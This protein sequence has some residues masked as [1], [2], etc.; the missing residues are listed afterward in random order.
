MNYCVLIELSK[1]KISFLY[2]RSDG[3]SRFV[4]FEGDG[5][6][7]PLAIFCQGNDIQIGQFAIDEARKGNP[8]AYVNVFDIITNRGTYKYRGEDCPYSTILF[9]AI[10]KYLS[11]FFDKILI[12]TL[13]HLEDNVA[14]MPLCFVFNSDI[15]ENQR[16]FVKNCFK[17]CGYNNVGTFDYDQI[18]VEASQYTTSYTVCV[19]SDGKDLFLNIFDSHTAKHLSCTEIQDKGYDPRIEIAIDLLW[20]SLG[21]S[22]LN[23]D[24][25]KEMLRHSAEDFLSSGKGT[26]QKKLMFSDGLERECSIFKSELENYRY[27]YDGS[28]VAK[29]KNELKKHDISLADC[30]IV[31]KGKAANNEYFRR[32]FVKDFDNISNVDESFRTRVLKQLLK[33]IKQNGYSFEKSDT[34]GSNGPV[35]IDIPQGSEP[36]QPIRPSGKISDDIK[37][38]V[39]TVKAEA[40][41]KQR[42]GNIN[43]ARELIQNLL[44]ELHNKGINDFDNELYHLLS[45]IDGS[46]GQGS[47]VDV[48]SIKREIRREIFPAI[49]QRMSRQDY[50]GASELLESVKENIKKYSI[51][52]LDD[53]IKEFESR[54]KEGLLATHNDST[55]KKK[56]RNVVQP[57]EKT[58]G[59]K[60]DAAIARTSSVELKL[61]QDGKFKDAK[62]KYASAGNAEMVKVCSDFIKSKRNIKIF[63][64]SLE[65]NLRNNNQKTKQQVLKEL[66]Q[67]RVLYK[68]YNVDTTEIDELLKQYNLF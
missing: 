24:I 49:N 46:E 5:Q 7:L 52:D 40:Q 29:L 41:G 65:I 36:N 13:K 28:V 57:K 1:K 26:Y 50:K 11:I 35:P 30:T 25:E 51:N 32:M 27:T 17:N 56:E 6:A 15:A 38:Q 8:H 16:L 63:Q 34:G 12:G 9:N 44:N 22:Y 19:T 18:V 33:D 39:R 45:E 20:D 61:I 3:E 67:Y 21:Y 66:K 68:Q 60:S 23:K 64:D 58:A 47:I 42:S 37:R 53:K 10:Q 48:K 4:S 31:L 43:G 62:Q 54:I 14:K 2:N 59:V 55:N